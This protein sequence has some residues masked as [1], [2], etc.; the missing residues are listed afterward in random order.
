MRLFTN[1]TTA[2][3]I[4]T[5]TDLFCQVDNLTPDDGIFD[6][7]K[8]EFEYYSKIRTI[9]FDGLS[10]SPTARFLVR[11]S[12]SPESVLDIEFEKVSNK[13]FLIYHTCE[14]MIWS[15]EKFEK[16]KVKKYRTEI[17]KESAELV[18]SLFLN[19]IM[20]TK[21]PD[22]EISGNDGTTY[23]FAVHYFGMKSGTT[24]SPPQNTK[25]GRLVDIGQELIELAT[26]NRKLVSIEG[27]LKDKIIHLKNEGK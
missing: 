25:M 22:N 23:A 17:T 9:L 6:I 7:Y 26:G 19:F 2:I 20:Q 10:D 24:W 11:P 27:E 5:I 15:N 8:F 1:L 16:I 13:Y 12:F 21:Y 14:E 3:L 4:F 18:K